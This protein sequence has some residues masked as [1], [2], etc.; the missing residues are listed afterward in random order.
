M[1]PPH[2]ALLAAPLLSSRS[3]QPGSILIVHGSTTDVQ[4]GITVRRWHVQVMAWSSVVPLP[5]PTMCVRV[6]ISLT[7]AGHAGAFEK[8]YFRKWPSDGI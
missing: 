4:H 5:V 7:V 3:M 1:L 2:E 8:C 6:S